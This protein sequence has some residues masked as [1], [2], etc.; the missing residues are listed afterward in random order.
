MKMK[1]NKVLALAPHTDDIEIGCGGLLSKLKSTAHI[2]AIAFTEA[3]PL[4]TGSPVD[5][6]KESMKIVNATTKFM[7]LKPRIMN[8]QRQ[9]ILDMLWKL[10]NEVKY[11]LVLCPSSSDMHQDHQVIYNECFRAFKT[12]TIFGYELL[13]NTRSFKTDIFVALKEEHL[14]EKFNMIDCY[15]TQGERIFMSKDYVFDIARTRGLQVGCKYAEAY[16]AIRIV[17]SL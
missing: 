14:N 7:N 13:W 17:D 3:Q 9:I 16:E 8:E 10:N 1:F 2:D 12:T 6:F 4:S 5:E 15:K 11:D